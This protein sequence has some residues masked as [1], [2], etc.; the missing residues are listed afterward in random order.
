MR[1]AHAMPFGAEITDGG[2]RFALWAPTA[3]EV[4]LVLDGAERPMP[5]EEGGWRRLTAPEARAGSRYAYRVDNGL[6]VPDP[7]SRFQPDD[8]HRE[9]LVVDPGA[10]AWADDGWTGRPWEEAVL[11]ELH[12]GTA[13]P[14]GTYA[15]LMTKLA[16]LRDA[17]VTAIEFMPLAEFPGRRN[18]GYDGVLPFAPDAAYGTPDDLKRLVDRAHALGLMVF[19]DVVYNHF[20]PA[21]NYLNAYARSFFTERHQTPWGAGINFDGPGDGPVR[22]FFV[23]NALYWLEE[24]H[25]DGLRF[26]AVHAILDDSSTHIIAEIAERARAAFP[27]R[28]VHLV[29]E[30]DAN[31]ARW[32]PRDGTRPRLHTAQ[33]N[34]D[35]HHCW[36]TLLTGEADGYYVD[37]ADRPVERLARCLTQGFAYQ[38]EPSAHRG[39]EARGEPSAHLPPS[40]FVGFLQNHDQIG[41]RAFGERI[42]ALAA[43]ERLALAHAGL[44]LSPQ[45]PLL[46]MGEE[47]AASTPF[48]YFVDF[49]DDPALSDAVR[50][51]RQREFAN[52]ASFA[53]GGERRIPDPTREDTFLR[54]RLDWSERSRPPHADIF[55]ETRRLLEIRRAAIVPLT[56]TRFIEA[57][58]ALPDPELLDVIWRFE[59][60]TLRFVANFGDAAR[61]AAIGESGAMIWTSPSVER[62]RGRAGLPPWTGFFVREAAR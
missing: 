3:R 32:L 31:E 15:G 53:A 56:K 47:W 20:G 30:N 44:L 2:V 18:W 37:Y 23:H 6:L 17:G 10:F 49:A 39:G 27:N 24:Y 60:G 13:T 22:D 61:E 41:N 8:V 40:A 26:D 1:R 14:E 9:S 55:A 59:G 29:L 28:E 52:F 21:G 50:E 7:A 36:H 4:A 34:D 46:Y 45:I 38:G 5:Q 19:I 48:L 42:G 12:V 16:D 62:Q 54:S 51:G 33:W 25:V 57:Q 35:L 43:P 58:T 11:Y